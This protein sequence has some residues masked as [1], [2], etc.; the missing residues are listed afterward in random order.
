M[1]QWKH[2]DNDLQDYDVP[3][4]DTDGYGWPALKTRNRYDAFTC[5]ELSRM[6]LAMYEDK[7][8]TPYE[9][10][11]EELEELMREIAQARNWVR[12]Q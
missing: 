7:L 10:K 4:H 6:Y 11:R 3:D 1:S 5:N 2:I 12:D 9:H 8:R